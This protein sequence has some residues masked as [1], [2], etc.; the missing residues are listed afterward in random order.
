M[1]LQPSKLFSLEGKIALITGSTRGIGEALARGFA[2]AGA[3]VWVHGREESIGRQLAEELGGHFI[4]A[5]LSRS[6]EVRTVADTLIAAESRL[7]ILVNNAGLEI[8]MP[9]EEMDMFAFDLIWQVNVRAAVELVRL[10]LPLLERSSAGSIINITSIHDTVPYPNNA[11]YSMSK[12]ALA[13]FTKVVALEL[14][15]R[16]IRVNNFAPGAVETE[17]NRDV[18]DAIGRDKFREWI[19]LGRVATT[20]EMIGPALFLASDASSYVTGAT[21][22]VDGGYQQ[23]LVRYRPEQ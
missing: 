23:N 21:L 17:I 3:K 15:P 19:P 4:E 14:A 13:M 5:D 18:L 16:A 10:L 22:Y 1:I 9:L 7:D 2:A 12:A 11:A 20:H 8:V 6:E